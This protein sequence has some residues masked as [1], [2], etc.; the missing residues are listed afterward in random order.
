V[1]T[2][3]VGAAP[4]PI[5]QPL[6]FRERN[7]GAGVFDREHDPWTDPTYFDAHRAALACV[8]ASVVHEHGRETVDPLCRCRDYRGSRSNPFQLQV[9]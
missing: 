5:E 6:T 9:E 8:L 7:A 2:G 1:T 3:L 4:E